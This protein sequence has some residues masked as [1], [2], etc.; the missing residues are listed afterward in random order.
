MGK[1]TKT[2]KNKK[3]NKRLMWCPNCEKEIKFLSQIGVSIKTEKVFDVKLVNNDSLG[4][5]EYDE[6]RISREF[7]CKECG[8][9]LFGDEIFDKGINYCMGLHNDG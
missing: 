3:T 1:K 6:I 9:V 8:T 7:F 5:D 2:P 4:Y